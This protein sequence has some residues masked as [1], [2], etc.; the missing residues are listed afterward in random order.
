MV[1]YV[2]LRCPLYF[3]MGVNNYQGII[4]NWGI[5]EYAVVDKCISLE[6]R[7]GIGEIDAQKREGDISCHNSF[8]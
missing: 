7:E 3:I 8:R 2:I 6:L 4:V 1:I 5:Q